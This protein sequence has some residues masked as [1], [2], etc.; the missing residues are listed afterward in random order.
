MMLS[1]EDVEHVA[2]LARLALSDQELAL[3]Q[4]QLSAILEHFE[5]LQQLET[6]AIEPTATVL[7]L[8]SVMRPD[9]AKAPF[10]RDDILTNAPDAEGG[11][12]RVPAVMD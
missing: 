5:Q 12:F 11:C 7:P 10:A 4:G 2:E 9:E 8:R 1:R 3:Y 6:G